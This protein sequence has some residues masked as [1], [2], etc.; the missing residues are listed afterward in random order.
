MIDFM[1]NVGSADP[2]TIDVTESP[3]LVGTERSSQSTNIDEKPLR[4]LPIDQ[5]DYLTIARLV[6]AVADSEA[7][8]D[9]ND[10][11]VVQA[12]QS[13]ISFNGNNG[14]GNSINVDG[15][16]ANDSGGGF[17]PT[18]SQEAVEEFQVNRSNYSAE[19]G[20]AS[21]GVINIISKSGTNLWH[22]SAFGFFRT[23]GLDAADPFARDS[24]GWNARADQAPVEPPAI[25]RNGRRTDPCQW[26]LHFPG[27]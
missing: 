24:R 3:S 21:G 11:R 13:G 25:R 9:N 26:N 4:G 10:F 7:L 14:R 5:R 15:G 22:G 27:L 18:L 2:V 23:S 17:R 19:F 20:S 16:E 1:L 8:A 6:P 12:A